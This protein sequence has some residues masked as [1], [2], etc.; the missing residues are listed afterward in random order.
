MRGESDYQ[1]PD[2]STAKPSFCLT[3]MSVTSLIGCA[4]AASVVLWLCILAVL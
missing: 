3:G 4:V 1:E 2:S